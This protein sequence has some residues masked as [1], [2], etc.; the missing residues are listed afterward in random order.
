MF[1]W[2][3]V[4]VVMV[5]IWFALRGLFICVGKYINKI[6]NDT[7][8]ILESEDKENNENKEESLNE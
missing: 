4:I 2:L 6:L 3:L 1:F 7:K 5:I 8:E